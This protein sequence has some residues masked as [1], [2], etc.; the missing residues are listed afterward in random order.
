MQN[1]RRRRSAA[2]R[3]HAS[4]DAGAGTNARVRPAILVSLAASATTVLATAGVLVEGGALRQPLAVLPLVG[5]IALMTLGAGL[6]AVTM[7]AAW[8]GHGT[9]RGVGRVPRGSDV[10]GQPLDQGPR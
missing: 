1:R 5:T 3:H 9:S 10:V 8:Q 2:H 4:P 6:A 7:S